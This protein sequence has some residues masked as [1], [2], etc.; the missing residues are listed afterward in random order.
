M[1]MATASPVLPII[2]VNGL[3]DAFGRNSHFYMV[4][5][6][7]IEIHLCSPKNVKI[8]ITVYGEFEEP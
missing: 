4:W 1:R 3:N 8:C 6:R 7:K 2:A 5:L